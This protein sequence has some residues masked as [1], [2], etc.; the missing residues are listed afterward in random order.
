VII[1]GQPFDVG[2]LVIDMFDGT[3]N[4]LVLRAVA[5]ETISS[6]PQKSSKKLN[7]DLREMFKNVPRGSNPRGPAV[8]TM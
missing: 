7:S 5:T 1:S 8:P 6:K 3:S 2:T 4:L